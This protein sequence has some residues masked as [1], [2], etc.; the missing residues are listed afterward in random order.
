MR[1]RIVKNFINKITNND[2]KFILLDKSN[3][4]IIYKLIKGKN[5]IL[6]KVYLDNFSK[7]LSLNEVRGHRYFIKNK[8]INTPKL[9]FFKRNSKFNILLRDFI[10][11]EKKRFN[12][13]KLFN[14]YKFPNDKN[15]K[16]ITLENYLKKNFIN[17][18][19][20][21][22][23]V[24][25]KLTKLHKNFIIVCGPSHGDLMHYN[26][27][28]KGNKNYFIDFE[29]FSKKR[30]IYFDFFTWF[31]I[32]IITKS[33]KYKVT[34]LIHHLISFFLYIIYYSLNQKCVTKN[35]KNYQ[36]YF[37]VFL[38]EKICSMVKIYKQSSFQNKT[39]K[40][41]HLNVI[42]VLQSIINKRL[43]N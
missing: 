39:L 35:F 26:L 18:N 34:F 42:Q 15:C 11:G 27:L 21:Q 28:T 32:P 2:Y 17:V 10:I 41:R 25:N 37:N 13:F 24:I 33:I 29:F 30:S 16:K 40:I 4:K 19:D 5:K 23:K 20:N 12:Y 3:N 8:F 36:V 1:E 9:I 6:A 7:S 38:F 31:I 22:K 14:Y 43:K